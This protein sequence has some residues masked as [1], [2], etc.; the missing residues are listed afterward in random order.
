MMKHNGPVLRYLK[1]TTKLKSM[2]GSRH[3]HIDEERRLCGW[4]TGA[5]GRPVPSTP[6]EVRSMGLAPDTEG[7]YRKAVLDSGGNV[8]GM[9]VE[10]HCTAKEYELAASTVGNMIEHGGY[11]SFHSVDKSAQSS[12]KASPGYEATLLSG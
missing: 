11:S 1:F 9:G 8:I 4:F 5:D 7:N 10:I 2:K 6:E 3:F 12:D